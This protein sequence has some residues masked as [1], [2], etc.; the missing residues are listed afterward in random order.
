LFHWHKRHED[1]LTF[2]ERIAD[3]VAAI[4]GSWPFIIIQSLILLTWILWNTL[5]KDPF[6]PYPFILL[7]LALSFQAAYAAPFIMISQNRQAQKDRHQ[8]EAD[9]MTNTV[10]K[11]EIEALQVHLSR[12]ENEKLDLIL[13]IL[14]K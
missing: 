9:Y 7:N 13:Q 11:Q 10:A 1:E 5:T 2:G 12:I 14:R 3:K 6:D 8:A 4:V